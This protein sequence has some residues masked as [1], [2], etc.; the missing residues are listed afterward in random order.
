MGTTDCTPCHSHA[1]GF[2]PDSNGGQDCA[3]CHT[4]LNSGTYH[5]N[6]SSAG[7]CLNC[8]AD[9]NIFRSDLNG[10]NTLGRAANLR[11]DA[12]VLPVAGLP[13]TQSNTD[14]NA[15]ATNGGLCVSCHLI[16]QTKP[17]A[18]QTAIVAKADFAASVHN[19]T[20]SST[21]DKDKS[22]FLANCSKCH[23]DNAVKKFQ[24]AGNQFSTHGSSVADILAPMGDPAPT[25]SGFCFRCH[26]Q[27]S[28]TL[29]GTLKPTAGKD[30]YGAAAM[31]RDAEGIFAVFQN[32]GSNHDLTRVDCTDCHSTHGAMA[33]SHTVGTNKAGPPL[34]GASGVKLPSYPAFW[35][36]PAAGD[37]TAVAAITAGTDLEAYVCF[38]CHTA[39]VGTLPSS[40]SGSFT[41]TDVAKE[42]NPNNKGAFTGT[43]ANGVTAGG[44]HPV[45]ATAGS[46]LGAVKLAGLNTAN[47]AWSTSSRN[48]MTC[49]DC[50]GADST[51]DPLGPHGSAAKFL[52]RGPNTTWTSAQIVGSSPN[53]FPVGSFC[54]NCHL[55]PSSSTSRFPG[56]TRGDHRSVPCFNCH[57]AVP[58]GGPRMGMLVAGA[59]ANAN[60]GGVITGWDQSSPYWQGT[61]S[62]RLYIISY[63]ANNTTDWAESN[64]GCNSSSHGG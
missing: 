53:Y 43:W 2:A 4:T 41:T 37:F 27:V 21:I 33:G 44:F 42:F 57:A 34:H 49:S 55:Q 26:S 1:L 64:C 35:S 46:N 13:A 19:Y 16:P 17:D 20:A 18:T 6:L 28:D 54:L 8:H 36:A 58:H 60:V 31:S 32:T 9:H 62:N 7:A 47:I 56:H 22:T 63:P 10:A 40:P 51:T 29:A 38:K 14:F 23:S 11:V 59:G 52:L 24:S 25:G 3:I 50:H 39:S 45:L 5:H 12:A 15:A 30:Y 48:M 61:S